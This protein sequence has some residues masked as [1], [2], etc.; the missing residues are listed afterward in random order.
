MGSFVS[1]APSDTYVLK[2]EDTITHSNELNQPAKYP[3]KA[4]KVHPSAQA[5]LVKTQS[6]LMPGGRSN[7]IPLQARPSMPNLLVPIKHDKAVRCSE[8]YS[9]LM[10][11]GHFGNATLNDFEFG[12]VIG[13]LLQ[14]SLVVEINFCFFNRQRSHGNGSRLQDQSWKIFCVKKCEERLY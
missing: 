9:W 3:R 5:Q 4:S 14:Y 12:R 11:D 2:Y 6:Q 1:S 10:K 13:M 7:Q 8:K